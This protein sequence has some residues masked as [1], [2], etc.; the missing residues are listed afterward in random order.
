M[1]SIGKQLKTLRKSQRMTQQSVADRVGITR[2]TLSNYEIDRRTPDLKTLRK[3][4]ECFGVNLDYFGVAP[5]DD[6]LDL[7]ARAKDVFENDRI[8]D[9]RK[10]ELHDELMKLY[11][12]LK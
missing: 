1:N 3:L 9:E 4:A 10:R 7:L 5:A 8:S 11:L 12:Q 2:A 6:V